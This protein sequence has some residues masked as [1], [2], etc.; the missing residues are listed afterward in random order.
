MDQRKLFWLI[1]TVAS[2]LVGYFLPLM[3]ALIAT[4]PLIF[5]C[6]WIVYRSGWV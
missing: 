6:W 3:W 4:I 1:F 5:V 2:L